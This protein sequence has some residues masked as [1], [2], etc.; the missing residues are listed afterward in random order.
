MPNAIFFDCFSGIS[1]DMAL[2]ALLDAGLSLDSLRAELGKLQ[3]DGWSIDAERGM[4]RYLA[5]TRA[6]VLAPE[7]S[8]HRHLSDVQAIIDRSTLAPS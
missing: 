1:G 4:R 8:T 2:G 5:G 6:L 7:Q 3:L